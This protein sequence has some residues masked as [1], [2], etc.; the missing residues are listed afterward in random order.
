MKRINPTDAG[1]VAAIVLLLGLPVLGM[2][3]ASTVAP[4]I[5]TPGWVLAT[6]VSASVLTGVGVYV[7]PRRWRPNTRHRRWLYGVASVVVFELSC[8]A[9]VVIASRYDSKIVLVLPLP[10]A[11]MQLGLSAARVAAIPARKRQ[12]AARAYNPSDLGRD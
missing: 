7:C 12:R 10:V 1:K 3:W 5:P 11:A 6:Y 2:Y 9:A 8:L 4:N